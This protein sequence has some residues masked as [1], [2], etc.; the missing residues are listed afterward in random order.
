MSRH[1]L[2][3]LAPFAKHTIV[4]GWDRP[5]RTYYVQVVNHSAAETDDDTAAQDDAS[6]PYIRRG[7][8]FEEI[9]DAAAAVAI[10]RPYAEI[11]PGLVAQLKTEQANDPGRGVPVWQVCAHDEYGRPL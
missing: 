1:T 10:V 7:C 3:P 9:T 8:D 2:T 4:I 11:P 6:N 5:L